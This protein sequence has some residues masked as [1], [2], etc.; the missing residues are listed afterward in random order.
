MKLRKASLKPEWSS[1]VHQGH[2]GACKAEV[3]FELSFG[4]S[5]LCRWEGVEWG[6]HP[7][8]GAGS[9]KAPEQM[10]CS[11]DSGW[12]PGTRGCSRSGGGGVVVM[13]GEAEQMGWDVW[14]L[15]RMY[16]P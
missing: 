14:R 12:E 11:A 2:R 8:G 3:A 10:A 5:G 7:G 1:G 15:F 13:R 9:V 6:W 4:D 16:S